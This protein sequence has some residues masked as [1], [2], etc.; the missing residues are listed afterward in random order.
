MAFSLTSPVTGGAQTGFTSPT[1]TVIVDTPPDINAKQY[2]VSALGGTQTG[3][4]AHAVGN[5]F[6]ISM[7]RP[8]QFKQLGSPNP[9]T[10]V[11][12]NV[13]TNSWKFIVRKGAAPLAGQPIKT[14]VLTLT[15]D[16]P[17]GVEVA[18]PAEIRGALS[19]LFGSVWQQSAALGDTLVQGVL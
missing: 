12:S 6:T 19:A 5:P 10:G 11:I 13:P 15:I 14:M 16:L 8:K 3:V 2:V 1:Y 7:F 4:T 9:A 17:A 18:N